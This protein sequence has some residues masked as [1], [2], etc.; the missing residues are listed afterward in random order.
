MV[1]EPAVDKAAAA[2]VLAEA[3]RVVQAGLPSACGV[4]I[5]EREAPAVLLLLLLAP[6]ELLHGSSTAV[7]VE[8]LTVPSERARWQRRQVVLPR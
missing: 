4:G 3:A 8:P 5:R 7:P 1:G 6:D 2:A